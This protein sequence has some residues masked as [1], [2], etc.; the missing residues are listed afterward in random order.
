MYALCNQTAESN[1]S[2]NRYIFL[3]N[4]FSLKVNFIGRK[5]VQKSLRSSI[6]QHLIILIFSGIQINIFLYCF[7][8]SQVVQVFQ[9]IY[10]DTFS[11]C[12]RHLFTFHKYFLGLS[13]GQTE[14]DTF[15]LCRIFKWIAEKV[16]SRAD[17]NSLPIYLLELQ[18]V[19]QRLCVQYC[20]QLSIFYKLL[21]HKQPIFTYVFPEKLI[22]WSQFA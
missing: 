9:D 16:R 20:Q 22:F 12:L 11:D 2:E 14:I 3:C 7:S 6:K 4:S 13:K 15:L 1:F 18:E 5:Q 21:S 10:M 17:L 8:F 19:T